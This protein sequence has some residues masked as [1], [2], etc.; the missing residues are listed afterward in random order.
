M[1]YSIKVNQTVPLNLFDTGVIKEAYF[2]ATSGITT[3]ILMK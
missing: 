2:N 3:G 1:N